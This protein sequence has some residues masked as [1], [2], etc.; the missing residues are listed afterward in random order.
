MSFG[1]FILV[2]MYL[3]YFVT[4]VIALFLIV[5][6]KD[7]LATFFENLFEAKN[8]VFVFPVLLPSLNIVFSPFFFVGRDYNSFFVSPPWERWKPTIAPNACPA[9]LVCG[10]TFGSRD[11]RDTRLCSVIHSRFPFWMTGF[12][13]TTSLGIS[14]L[15][16][17]SFIDPKSTVGTSPKISLSLLALV[18]IVYIQLRMQRIQG[19]NGLMS[20]CF[21]SVC[22]RQRSN[23]LFL[24]NQ[25]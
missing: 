7:S 14:T 13:V 9:S 21:A 4:F 5:F 6:V 2:K 15:S 8:G 10:Q 24:L 17:G 1:N 19:A 25:M 11:D 23:L 3:D 22:G 12:E 20:A 16:I 18:F